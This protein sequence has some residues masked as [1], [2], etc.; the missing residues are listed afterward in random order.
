MTEN[1]RQ[2]RPSTVEFVK[3]EAE[4]R[5]GIQL[6][7]LNSDAPGYMMAALFDPYI[8]SSENNGVTLY[9]NHLDCDQDLVST[10]G[11]AVNGPFGSQ[12][13][14][15]IFPSPRIG[16]RTVYLSFP[17][18]R[19]RVSNEWKVLGTCAE[20]PAVAVRSGKAIFAFDPVELIIRYLDM[21][22]PGVTADIIDLV[23]HSILSARG[24]NAG[25]DSDD[26]RRD[27]HAL[28]ISCMM[29]WELY[30]LFGKEWSTHELHSILHEAAQKYIAGRRE[31]A[32][33][34]LLE[35]YDILEAARKRLVPV[36]VYIMDM[37]HGGILF[38][39]EGY[40]EYDWPEAAAGVLRMYLDWTERFGYHFA[41]DI[42]AGTLKNFSDTHPKTIAALKKAW[43]ESSIEFVNGTYSQPYLQLWDLWS[44]E[45]QFEVG[46]GVFRELF[47]RI[48]TAYA[49][50]EIALHPG[51][52]RILRKFGYEYAIHRAQ[53]LGTT[54]IENVPL[55]DW[56]GFD[57]T[58]IPALPSHSPRSEKLG[59]DIYRNLPM[60]LKK[61]S[62]AGLPFAAYTNLI[63]QTFVGIYKEEVVRAAG[64]SDVWGKFVTPTGFF[65]ETSSIERTPRRYRLDA[66]EYDKELP[67]E[68]YHRHESGGRSSLL[69]YWCQTARKL[70]RQESGNTIA[71]G[72]LIR[73]LEGQAHDAYIVPYFKRGAF[74][75]L[76]LTDY[77]GPRY[78]VTGDNPRGVSHYL[79]DC[80]GIPAEVEAETPVEMAKANID[81]DEV[82][83]GELSVSIDLAT[84]AVRE[85]NKEQISLG[86]L[87]YTGNSLLKTE[88]REHSGCLEV[89]GQLH[90]FGGAT[91]VYGISGQ[92]LYCRISAR[93][94]GW[95]PDCKTPYWDDCV[96]LAHTIP[97]G[98]EVVR[99][100]SGFAEVTRLSYF[101]S[102]GC[103]QFKNDREWVT[104]FHG[105]NIFFR[106]V[107]NEIHNMLWAYNDN[108]VSFWWGVIISPDAVP[109]KSSVRLKKGSLAESAS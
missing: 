24:E 48:P 30:S 16:R 41:P 7:G 72:D 61:T 53:N 37:P 63:D 84:G 33:G 11:V 31:I 18:Y 67:P 88:A 77:N 109:P 27:F 8:V 70:E 39:Q 85:I 65:Q 14:R 98:A 29:L 93:P 17:C 87:T 19:M 42:G 3:S 36:P 45:K 10:E 102:H 1:R 75:E 49:A 90:G 66:Y 43:Q 13:E 82:S 46:L 28:G 12:K 81:T 80:V 92:T 56:E 76:Y 9:L 23:V 5:N 101:F 100:C 4:K 51:L 32:S 62:D 68:N 26:T 83:L 104:L 74:M 21:A 108:A 54:P 52:P 94:E 99:H 6:R 15:V 47:E 105:G 79:R 97:E 91:L 96:Y 40:A 103:L 78:I 55:I 44:Q 89:S 38:Q 107:G 58:T 95:H 25:F 64:L 2:G 20:L 34:K 22:D 86:R 71:E 73:L 69:E 35:C 50:Q 57:G 60:L 106:R 59:S